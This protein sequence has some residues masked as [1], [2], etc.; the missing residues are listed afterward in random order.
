MPLSNASPHLEQNSL[1][2]FG[3]RL[4]S[5]AVP[6]SGISLSSGTSV[7]I[8]LWDKDMKMYDSSNSYDKRKDEKKKK[9]E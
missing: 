5:D 3:Q 1:N 9:K 8:L 7:D 6:S 2:R 4:H